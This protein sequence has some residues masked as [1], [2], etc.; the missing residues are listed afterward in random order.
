[1]TMLSIMK[2]S[3]MTLS[4]MTLRIMTFIIIKLS[5]TIP[6]I[7]A[8][9][10]T[11]LSKMEH[12]IKTQTLGIM[13]ISITIKSTTLRHNDTPLLVSFMLCPNRADYAECR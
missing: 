5:A 10:L 9:G 8:L 2:L 4:K 3:K 13:T 7:M 12:G 1:M 6:S 11:S